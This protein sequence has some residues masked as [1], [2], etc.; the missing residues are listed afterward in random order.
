MKEKN[1]D[2]LIKKALFNLL[3]EEDIKHFEEWLNASDLNKKVFDQMKSEWEDIKQPWEAIDEEEIIDKIWEQSIPSRKYDYHPNY[4]Q[5]WI[6]VFKIAA[7]ISLIFIAY[8]LLRTK[9]ATKQFD[10]V[11]FHQIEKKNIPGQKSKIHLSDGTMVWLNAEST[12]SYTKPF[13]EDLR[14][15]ELD[16]EAYFEVARDVN[17]PFIVTIQETQVRVLGTSFNIASFNKDDKR[18]IALSEGK[19]QITLGNVS[20][21]LNQGWIAEIDKKSGQLESYEGNVMDKIA[22]TKDILLFKNASYD[23]IF[24]QLQR[25]YGVN[26]KIVGKPDG[27]MKFTGSFHNEYLKNVLENLIIENQ[28]TYEIDGENVFINFN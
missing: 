8:F 24:E 19:I 7:S 5:R 16:G 13:K 22:W 18:I 6:Q 2:S 9:P 25:W 17:R 14:E 21:V 11:S 27:S 15:V 12:L 28:M 10:Q 23:E 1:I 20:Q 4:K 3:N 26:I